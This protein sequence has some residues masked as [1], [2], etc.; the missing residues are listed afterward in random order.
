MTRAALPLTLALVLVAAWGPAPAHA[1]CVAL[2]GGRLAL[3]G[4]RPVAGTLVLEDAR[5]AEAGVGVRAPDGC[6]RIAIDGKIVTPGLIDASSYLGL[7][8]IDLEPSTS[9]R[10][11]G[12]GDPVRAAFRA[13]DGYNPHS[14]LIPVARAGGVT[15]AVVTPAGGLVAGQSAWVD[16]SGAT[17]KEAVLRSPVAVIAAIDGPAGFA[18]RRLRELFQDA[19][20]FATRRDA[21]EK[22]Q[23]R[24][25]PWSRPDLEA[26]RPVIAG[27]VPLVVGAD[28]ASDIEALLRFAA[29]ESIRVV[30]L[31]GAEAH[32]LAPELAAAGVPVIVDPL[33]YGPG[34]FDQ[35]HGRS[36]NAALLHAAG[37]TVAIS[38]YSAHSLRKLPQLAGNAVR[39]GLP[40]E[41]ALEAI[42][43]AP[44]RI[45]GITDHGTL[46]RGGVANVVVWSGDP[47]EI[48]S[49]VEQVWIA[50]RPYEPRS[51]QT[52]LFE[53]YRTLPGT[54]PGALPLPR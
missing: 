41:V 26:L 3:A 35:L 49:A 30:V 48:G 22:N 39:D 53:R 11:A 47:L 6:R 2:T 9:D 7:V 36:D 46:A 1:D 45:F 12:G 15:S 17:Q 24:Q 21:W 20:L 4:A 50:G 40:W 5:I 32:L 29:E 27:E 23:S 19:R 14:T 33:V 10:D 28:R 25:F 54:P 18:L 52:E 37:V 43:A 51:R 44:A 42:T 34:S 8:E 13:A 38:S 16:L 31:G